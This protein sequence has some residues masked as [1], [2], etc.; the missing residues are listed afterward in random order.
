MNGGPGACRGKLQ[1]P[2]PEA[3]SGVAGFKAS[4]TNAGTTSLS[5]IAKL[6]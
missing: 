4:S 3:L 6:V 2:V 5:L 1:P